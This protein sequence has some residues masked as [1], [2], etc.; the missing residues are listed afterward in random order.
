M[1]LA[2]ARAAA[3]LIKVG[4]EPAVEPEATAAPPVDTVASVVEQFMR[5]YMENGSRPHS[6]RYIE[7]TRRLFRLHVLPHWGDR[8]IAEIRRRDVNQLLDQIAD[9]DKPICANRCKSAL[10]KL[11]GWAA[12]RDLVEASPVIGV[13]KRGAEIARERVLSDHELAAVWNAGASY[14]VGPFVRLLTLTAQRRSEVA[15]MRWED[16]DTAK[17]IWTIPSGM[18]KSGR[19]QLVPLSDLAL[20]ILEQCPRVESCPYVFSTRRNRPISGYSKMKSELDAV[21]GVTGWRLHDLRRTVATRLGE[22][23]VQRFVIERVLNHAETSVT[24][25]HYDH[26]EYIEQ[27]R[28]ALDRWSQCVANL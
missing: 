10:S 5:R 15:G 25:R 12:N 1:G 27:K 22:L 17:R 18:T 26:G 8:S 20:R 3:M 11:F 23:G 24:G 14:P 28:D 2:E 7:E 6:S 16:V 19:S 9:S 4:K 21:T 13:E